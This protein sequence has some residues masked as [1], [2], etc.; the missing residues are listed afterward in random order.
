MQAED[1]GE[2]YVWETNTGTLYRYFFFGAACSEVE[3]DVLTG[4][5]V[6]LR[7]DMEVDV[8]AAIN[9]GV[10]IGQIEGTSVYDLIEL[11]HVE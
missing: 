5:H 10:D 2:D 11:P 3:I 6:V 8:G 7:T 1:F 4:E 9:P